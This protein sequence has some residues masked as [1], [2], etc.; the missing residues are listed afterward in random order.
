MFFEVMANFRFAV[1]FDELPLIFILNHHLTSYVLHFFRRFV[2]AAQGT[3]EVC[4]LIIEG[5]VLDKI[6]KAN[7]N[8]LSYLNYF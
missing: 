5:L 3:N 7:L 8:I 4:L 2:R 6:S 1:D